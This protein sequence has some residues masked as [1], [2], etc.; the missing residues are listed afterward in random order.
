MKPPL[1]VVNFKTYQ[2]ATG[3]NAVTL[4]HSASDVTRDTGVPV[5]VAPC[6]VDLRK[7]ASVA[8]VPIL[9]QH[10]DDVGYGSHTGHVP[11]AYVKDLGLWGTLLNHSE[12]TLPSDAIAR[13]LEAVG[14]TKLGSVLCI[15]TIARLKE[16]MGLGLQPSFLAIEPPELIG[17][18]RSVSKYR[19]DLIS[20][21]AEVAAESK[22]PLLCGAGIVEG[23]DV[24]KAME[25]GAEGILVASGVV[26]AKD[27]RA[28]ME[29]FATSL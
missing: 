25:L 24:R 29:E 23:R 28:V 26:K 15:G 14:Q 27:P 13:T 12:R 7:A 20:D 5:S 4:A 21:A 19:P 16:L 8:D 11:A 6:V 22:T 18:G 1:I 17:S 3:E 9:A 2:E 10:V